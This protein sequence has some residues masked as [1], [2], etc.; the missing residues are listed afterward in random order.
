[1]LTLWIAGRLPGLN[2]MLAGNRASGRWNSYNEVKCMWYGQIK[3]LALARGLTMQVPGQATLL[4]CE[5]NR[6][7]DPDNVVAGGAKILL[8]SL[9]GCEVLPGDDW[10]AVLGLHGFWHHTPG[11]AGCLFHWGDELLSKPEMLRLLEKE[12]KDGNSIDK[13]GSGS[14]NSRHAGPGAHHAKA[15]GGHASARSKLGR[16]AA[17]GR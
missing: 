10:T 8:D 12:G 3:L 6:K 9:V 15:A 7:R 11:R 14:G 17:V 16:R 2:E 13:N 1:M 4:F 5:P